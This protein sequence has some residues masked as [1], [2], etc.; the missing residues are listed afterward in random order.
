M[1]VGTRNYTGALTNHKYANIKK[2]QSPNEHPVTAADILGWF[3]GLSRTWV[4]EVAELTLPV[5]SKHSVLHV[6]HRTLFTSR[7]PH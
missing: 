7:R 6:D 2:T 4:T 1:N 5:S 3:D